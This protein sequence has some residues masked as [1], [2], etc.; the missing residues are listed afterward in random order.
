MVWDGSLEPFEPHRHKRRFRACW[1]G[2]WEEAESLIARVDSVL[3]CQR[4]IWLQWRQLY[5]FGRRFWLIVA[6]ILP[7]GL[8]EP[9]FWLHSGTWQCCPCATAKPELPA[10]CKNV[11]R[12]MPR[13]L[14]LDEKGIEKKWQGGEKCLH[15]LQRVFGSPNSNFRKKHL[16]LYLLFLSAS[17]F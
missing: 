12:A 3:P 5:N 13:G 9:W 1:E 2:S 8:W 17:F 10:W 6:Y 4:H 16:E 7:G 11:M 15:T 14:I